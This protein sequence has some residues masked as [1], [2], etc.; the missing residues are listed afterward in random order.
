[1]SADPGLSRRDF[2]RTAAVTGAVAGVPLP[3]SPLQEPSPLCGP[4]KTPIRLRINGRD[5]T[6][7]VEPRTTLLN[8]LRNH[9]EYTGCKE[10]CDRGACGACT[11][12][13]DGKPVVSCM[14]LAIDA[15]GRDIRTVEGLADGATLDPLQQKFV[16]KEGLQCGFCVPGF[17]LSIRAVLDRNPKATLDEIKQG[18][19][20]NLCRCAAYPG[21]FAAALAVVRK[22]KPEEDL[23]R[24]GGEALRK[25]VEERG[26][27]RVDGP[28]KVRGAAR[29]TYDVK[30]PGMLHMKILPSPFARATVEGE[31]DLAG[32]QAVP[33]V[34]HVELLT[35]N[36]GAIGE[37]VAVAIAADPQA[38][39]EAL[40]V[41]K[42]RLR[43]VPGAVTDPVR[44]FETGRVSAA[45][46]A[47]T[48][49]EA[50]AKSDS[51]RNTYHVQMVQHSPLEPHGVVVHPTADSLTAY[52]STQH[53]T[54]CRNSFARASGLGEGAVKLVC[55]HMGGGFGSKI[56]PW[57]FGLKVLE[58]A[59]KLSAPIHCMQPRSGELLRGGGRMPY[60][61]DVQLGADPQGRLVG[62]RRKA[63]G[64]RMG[65]YGYEVPSATDEVRGRV[66]GI[67]P[68]PALRA[69]GAPEAQIVMESILDDL[70]EKIGVDPLEIRLRNSRRADRMKRWFEEGATRIGWERRR[71]A[72]SD[73]GPRPHGFGVGCGEF[74]GSSGCCF[75]EVEVDR[76]LGLVRVAKAVAVLEGGFVNRRGVINQVQGGTLMGLSWWLTEERILDGPT[77]AMLN[78][79]FEFYKILGPRDV[80]DVEVVLLGTPGRPSGVGEAPVVPVGGALS[81]AIFNALGVRVTRP[82]FTPRHVLAALGKG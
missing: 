80:P 20:G 41:L 81:N 49:E 26:V 68:T 16:E 5:H 57:D 8:A 56:G 38:A 17:L 60:V 3:S 29:Y 74:A 42:V 72:G 11:V 39:D 69:P 15:A 75:L 66:D 33:G 63:L 13:L 37:A 25:A 64:Q 78:P 67:G 44:V 71:K 35:R 46:N 23:T 1:M 30:L 9:L 2:L 59:T 4:D 77:G 28:E 32:A 40:A 79:N 7:S 45:R 61:V 12:S 52:E 27:P 82:P 73:Q 14:M 62:D 54:G 51:V 47:E 24:L 18:C 55:E 65:P 70:A 50:L 21:M 76:E 34:R 53:I 10:V 43:P 58:F 19:S 48:I 31:P 36:P 6:L 22:E